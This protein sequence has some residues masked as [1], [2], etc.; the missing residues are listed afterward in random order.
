MSNYW[1]FGASKSL[2]AYLSNELCQSH[3][4]VS[5]SRS[6]VPLHHKNHKSYVVDF[7]DQDRTRQVINAEFAISRPD[8]AVFCQRFRPEASQGD[9]SAIKA[10][11]DVELGPVLALAEAA[12]ATPQKR[13]LSFVFVSSVAGQLTHIDIELYYHILK[14]VTITS[15]RFF[16]TQGAQMGLRANCVV[17]G[18]FEKYPRE[19]YTTKEQAKYEFLET[20]VLSQRIC[21]M[22]DIANIVEFLLSEKSS[23]LTGQTLN[24][25]GNLS[26]IAQESILRR[27]A[28]IEPT[29]R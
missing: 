28:P 29:R 17:L 18:E 4:V 14:S 1:I 6:V 7:A 27:L 3:Q 12:K 26:G 2:G 15:T 21:S 19:Q 16:A 13:P 9:L 10:G 23:Y 22:P 8:G 20:F 25:D 5:F 11:L 24:L